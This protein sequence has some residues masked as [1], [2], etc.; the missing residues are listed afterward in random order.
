MTGT[1]L[2][3]VGLL[4]EVDGVDT[5]GGDDAGA[6][7][8]QV[9]TLPLGLSS[10]SPVAVAVTDAGNDSTCPNTTTCCA[11]PLPIGPSGQRI[12]L[13]PLGVQP[14]PNCTCQLSIAAPDPANETSTAS[15]LDP[16]LEIVA[17]SVK[18]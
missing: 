4:V 1:V 18:L 3:T 17:T 14:G 8:D 10:P 15:L 7:S 2:V 12:E 5:A 9:A 16:G 11:P 6:P 13:V